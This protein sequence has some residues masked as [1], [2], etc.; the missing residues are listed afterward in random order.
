MKT[1][2]SKL[3]F[4]KQEAINLVKAIWCEW[5][6]RRITSVIDTEMTLQVSTPRGQ[7]TV[8]SFKNCFFLKS[9]APFESRLG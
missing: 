7:A 1:L 5:M 2:K 4:I 3:I 6:F 9:Y 8:V